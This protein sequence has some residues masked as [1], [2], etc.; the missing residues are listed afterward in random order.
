MKDEYGKDVKN[1]MIISLMRRSVWVSS[2]NSS[3]EMPGM[4][5]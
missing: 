1:K 5:V 2:K 4:M 3:I